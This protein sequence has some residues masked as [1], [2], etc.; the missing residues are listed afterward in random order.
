MKIKWLG[1]ASFLITAADGAKIITDPYCLGS[2]LSYGAITDSADIVTVG[3]DHMDHS[4]VSL[5]KGN[6]QVLKSPG[7]MQLKGIEFKGIAAHHDTSGG[8]ERGPI[9]IFRFVVDGIKV[10]HL[11]DLGHVPTDKQLKEIGDVDVLITPV[12]GLYTIDGDTATQVCNLIKPKVVIPMHYKT[13][14]CAYPISGVD[15]FLKGKTSVR[16]VDGSE[17]ELK[18][19]TL[20]KIMEIV[21]LNHAN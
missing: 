13:A 10:C 21:V 2:G 9:V 19:D 15:E 14:K 20:P 12:G 18:K 17:I 11:T 6:P 1:H 3:H 7:S 5:V 8:K 4:N 16:K